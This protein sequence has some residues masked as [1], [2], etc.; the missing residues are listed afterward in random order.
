[1]IAEYAASIRQGSF[2]WKAESQDQVCEEILEMSELDGIPLGC[3]A[4]DVK[5]TIL[6]QG[7]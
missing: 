4:T 6:I 2:H 7:Q 5:E 1:M 3:C